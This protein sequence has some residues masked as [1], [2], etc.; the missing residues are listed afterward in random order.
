MIFFIIEVLTQK[1]RKLVKIVSNDLNTRVSKRKK[2]NKFWKIFW[3]VI[4]VIVVGLGGVV[5]Y[6]YNNLKNAA[7]TAYRSGG[8]SDAENGSKSSVLNNSKPIAILL[9]GTDTGA[10]GRT[11]KG[12]TDSIMVAVLNPKTKKTTL[13]SFERDMQVNYRNPEYSPSKLNAAYAYGNAKELAK[14]LKKY[15][16]IP[17]N[18]YVLINMG[19]LKTIINKVGGVDITPTLAFTYEGYRKDELN[20][21]SLLPRAKRQCPQVRGR[22]ESKRGGPGHPGRSRQPPLRVLPAAR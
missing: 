22:N 13:V 1:D 19:G 6:E 17:I 4:A 11:Y 5:A 7:N 18:A 14:V 3:T 16:N 2:K 9:M 8:L 15:F 21:Q 20:S 12:R 10:L